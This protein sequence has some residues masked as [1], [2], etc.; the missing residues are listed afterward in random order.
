MKGRQMRKSIDLLLQ[1]T[2]PTAGL[3][4]IRVLVS[5][6]RTPHRWNQVIRCCF[7]V[8]YETRA[9]F[10]HTYTWT[11]EVLAQTL[12]VLEEASKFQL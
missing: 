11:A 8:S 7:A 4:R 3:R 1:V 9:R 10:A 2:T 6:D 12:V 5:P